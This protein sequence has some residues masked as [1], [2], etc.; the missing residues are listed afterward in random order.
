MRLFGKRKISLNA[1]PPLL[2]TLRLVLRGFDPSDAVD[3]LARAR[4]EGAGA[5]AS[6]P[7]CQSHEESRRT[8]EDFIRGGSTWAVVEKRSGHVIGAVALGP[9]PG[10]AVEGALELGY[11]LGE[12]YRD[13]GYAVEACA[14]VLA[15]AFDELDSPVAGMPMRSATACCGRNTGPRP[16]EEG[17]RSHASAETLR[18]R[19]ALQLCAGRVPRAGADEER[20]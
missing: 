1:A 9:D 3:V 10:R 13:Q 7:P 8:V 6:A 12:Q 17:R 2:Q 19:F 16:N 18:F 5:M 4:G 15:Y 20:A 14:A 11:T